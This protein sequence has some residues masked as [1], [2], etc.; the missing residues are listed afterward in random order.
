MH[1]PGVGRAKF[2]VLTAEVGGRW[3]HP[4]LCTVSAPVEGEGWLH[5]WSCL[6]GVHRGQILRRIVAR[7]FRGRMMCSVSVGVHLVSRCS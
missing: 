6:L 4:K 7:W 2:V 5:L 3:S 1:F